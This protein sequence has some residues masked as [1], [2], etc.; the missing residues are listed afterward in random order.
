MHVPAISLEEKMSF[1]QTQQQR[2]KK[3]KET[4]LHCFARLFSSTSLIYIILPSFAS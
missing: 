4:E 3:K 1:K 2:K